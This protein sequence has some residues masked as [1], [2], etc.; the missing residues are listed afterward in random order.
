MNIRNQRDF[1]AGLL[2]VLIGGAFSVGALSYEVGVGAQMG[3]GYFPLLVG[4][5]L[6]VVG[7]LIAA[8][9]CV[10]RPLDAGLIG[11]IAWKPLAWILSANFS[12]GILLG[13]VSWLGVPPLGLV[14]ATYSLVILASLA[15]DEF[16]L[17]PT[18]ILAT[19][20][21]V[22]GYLIFVKSLD[23]QIQAWPT[24]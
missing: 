1:V 10:R 21:A 3:P 15:T 16:K 11:K 9:A 17:R 8:M 24:L 12:F 18:L 22:G 6:T 5:A 14:V 19:V 13:G 7:A 20:L 4:A 2:F 23:L